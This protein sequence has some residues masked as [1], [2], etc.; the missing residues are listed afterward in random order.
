MKLSD[1]GEFGLINR[2]SPEFVRNLPDN[3]LGI[4]DDCA[5][6]PQ[7]DQESL[8][9]TTDMLIEDSHFLIDKISPEDLGYK[10][11]A[12]NLSDIAAMGGA[13]QSAFLSLGI[14]KNITVEWLDRFFSGLHQLAT[15][16]STHL[17]G[18]DTTKSQKH[19][20]INLVVLGKIKNESIKYRSSALPGDII[21]LTGDIGNSGGGLKILLENKDRD[22]NSDFLIKEHNRPQPHLTEGSWLS[23]HS[24]I[25]AMI[26]VS[27]GIDSDLR[28]IMEKSECGVNID[29]E[30]LPLSSHLITVC[31]L[32]DWNA[33]EIA[34]TGGED[35]CLLCTISKDDFKSISGEFHRHFKRPLHRIGEI[36]PDSS[37]LNYYLDEKKQ[38]LTGHGFDHFV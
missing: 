18:G 22:K 8:L 21:C 28:R 7:N 20:V 15:E 3:I 37:S 14:P 4:G 32:Y 27:D 36:I 30:S 24:A 5:V 9:V 1:I 34:A 19:L 33:Y 26:D 17:L 13:P 16:T 25:H 35:Y 12:V 38:K 23:N 6:L 10:S 11:L 2:F 29:L 31:D